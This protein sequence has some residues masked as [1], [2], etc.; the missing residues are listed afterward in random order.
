MFASKQSTIQ[1]SPA[2]ATLLIRNQCATALSATWDTSLVEQAGLKLLAKEAKLRAVSLVLAPTCNIQRVSS[3]FLLSDFS[4]NILKQNP[5]GG[6]VS[7]S[8]AE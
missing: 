2:Q 3:P 8:S 4:L 6:R 1:R 5:L 7:Q